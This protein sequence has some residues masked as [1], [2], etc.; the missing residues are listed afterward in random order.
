MAK[1]QAKRS[2]GYHRP[3]APRNLR[4][5]GRV[6]ELPA[7][8]AKQVN[9][10]ATRDTAIQKKFADE[11]WFRRVTVDARELWDFEP[12]RTRRYT[13]FTQRGFARDANDENPLTE[14]T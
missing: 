9:N 8:L 7:L 5:T 6:D 2:L 10:E 4:G 11:W 13:E 12:R 1:R 3:I 14:R